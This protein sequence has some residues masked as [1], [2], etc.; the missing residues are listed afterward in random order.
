VDTA[1]RT[2]PIPFIEP[3]PVMMQ[4]FPFSLEP[5]ADCE[6]WDWIFSI[7][8][9]VFRYELSSFGSTRARVFALLDSDMRKRKLEDTRKALQERTR[10]LLMASY[11]LRNRKI[12]GFSLHHICII[13]SARYLISAYTQVK[14]ISLASKVA[15]TAPP[16]LSL[17]F[18]HGTVRYIPK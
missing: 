13:R 4:T 17:N 1:T 6:R 8:A 14:A 7:R 15:L 3:T 11:W 5:R 2:H 18:D 16:Y 12:T 9:A 10:R